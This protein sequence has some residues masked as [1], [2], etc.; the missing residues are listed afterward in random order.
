MTTTRIANFAANAQL[1]NLVLRTQARVNESEV[2]VASE[3]KSQTYAGIASEAERLVNIENSRNLLDQFVQNNNL[4]DLRLSTTDTVYEGIRKTISDFREQVF[5]YEGG[6]QTIEQRVLDVQEAAF[7]AMK[8][9]ETHLNQDFNGRFLFGG[10]RV[11]FR[12][13][14]IS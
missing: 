13:T 1:V 10:T 3:K 12:A 11:I 9:I 5:I 14:G 6:G 7:R 2:Q 4:E 8:D